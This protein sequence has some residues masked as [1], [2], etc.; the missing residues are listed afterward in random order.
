MYNI[1]KIEEWDNSPVRLSRSRY[2]TLK[3]GDMWNLR[4]FDRW[5]RSNSSDLPWVI[6]DRILRS[7]IG[8]NYDAAFSKF[9]KMVMPHERYSFIDEFENCRYSP[10]Y[11]IDDNKNI[12]LNPKRYIRSKKTIR[13]QSFD[14]E[15]GYYDLLLKRFLTKKEAS[16]MW[17][18]NPKRFIYCIENG[19]ELTFESKKDPEYIRLMREKNKLI[20]LNKKAVKKYEKQKEYCFLTD[21]EKRLKESALDIQKRDAHGFDEDS[22]KGIEYH[23]QKRKRNK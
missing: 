13:F 6:A 15:Y 4:K 5:Y 18:S 21:A 20:R 14:L 12:Q 1:E 8:K 17:V 22:F 10:K 7:S 23:G 11:I 2:L 19:Y 16:R 9:C 3:Y